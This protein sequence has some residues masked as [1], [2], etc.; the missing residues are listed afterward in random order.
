MRLLTGRKMLLA[1]LLLA[2]ASALPM[3]ENAASAPHSVVGARYGTSATGALPDPLVRCPQDSP[4]ARR[5]VSIYLTAS[6]SAIRASRAEAGLSG[7]S[8]QAIELV[9]SG[10]TCSF[11]RNNRAGTDDPDFR[12]VYY[13]HPPTGRIIVVRIIISPLRIDEHGN[14]T[15]VLSSEVVNVYDANMVRITGVLI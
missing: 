10:S 7:V 3:G 9:T 6:N 5:L 1:I 12:D 11:I 14:I 13:R 4:A 2:L 8:P 15:G